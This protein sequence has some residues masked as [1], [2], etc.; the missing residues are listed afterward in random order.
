MVKMLM[1]CVSGISSQQFANHLNEAAKKRGLEVSC[2]ACSIDHVASKVNSFDVLLLGPI[3]NNTIKDLETTINNT[4]AIVE[5]SLDDFN[6]L[7]I[8]A[9][10]DKGLAAAK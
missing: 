9:I 10:L 5:L 8:D 6:I 7:N 4:A 2:E 3:A 1:A